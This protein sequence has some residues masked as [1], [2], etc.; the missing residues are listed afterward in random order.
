[1]IME[2]DRARKMIQKS[3]GRGHKPSMRCGEEEGD[4]LLTMHRY[5]VEM[6]ILGEKGR[7]EGLDLV[8]NPGAP[9]GHGGQW[10]M[11]ESKSRVFGRSRA[12][13]NFS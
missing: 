10:S 13:I 11:K 4:G 8:E 1:M 12:D 5:E 2:P 3:S 9:F 7:P 6:G